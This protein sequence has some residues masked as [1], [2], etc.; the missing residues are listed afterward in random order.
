MNELN[1]SKIMSLKKLSLL[2]RELIHE[3]VQMS[4]LIRELNSSEPTHE[5]IFQNDFKIQGEL[6]PGFR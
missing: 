1:F 6:R 5:L 3:L 2:T 4:L